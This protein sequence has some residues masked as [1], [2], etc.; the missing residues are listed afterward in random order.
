M[1]N[2]IFLSHRTFCNGNLSFI[3]IHCNVLYPRSGISGDKS[4]SN[5][6]NFSRYANATTN[7]KY[8]PFNN[9]DP[10]YSYAMN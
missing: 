9:Q 7:Y 3:L 10:H 8:K 2:C 4:A 5:K 6:L 1:R